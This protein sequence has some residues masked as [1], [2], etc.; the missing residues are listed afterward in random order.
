[1]S[2]TIREPL[3]RLILSAGF[4]GA[5]LFPFAKICLGC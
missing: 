4:L 3:T 2:T 5:T 1:M